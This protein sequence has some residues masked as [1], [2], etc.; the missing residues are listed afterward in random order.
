M[1]HVYALGAA[2]IDV[3][4]TRGGRRV[5]TRITP[6]AA[7]RFGLLLYLAAQ[8]GHRAP[9]STLRDLFFAGVPKERASHGLRELL[10]QVR[11]SGVVI[12]G[13]AHVV[14]LGGAV[15]SDWQELLGDGPSDASVN[16]AVEGGFLPGYAPAHSAEY[17]KWFG[18]FRDEMVVRLR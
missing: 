7:K 1:I 8:P 4:S 13:D 14:E 18:A 5:T 16:R 11:R 9:R 3:V 12:E 15:R 2:R 6:V 17:S 10:Y